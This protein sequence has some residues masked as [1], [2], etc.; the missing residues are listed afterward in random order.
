MPPRTVLPGHPTV[1]P[2][3]LTEMARSGDEVANHKILQSLASGGH[4]DAAL[5]M[6]DIRGFVGTSEALSDRT[7]FFDRPSRENGNS[8]IF[9]ASDELLPHLIALG[10]CI[11]LQN[12]FGNTALHNACINRSASKV[13]TLLA[14][15]ARTDVRNSRALTAYD[16][17]VEGSSKRE[18]SKDGDDA[19]RLPGVRSVCVMLDTVCR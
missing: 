9:Y 17:L 3:E 6:S 12:E 19:E 4:V 15:G 2:V 8:L 14:A 1:L 13:E 7:G 18:L 16:V 11:N 5:H 10:A